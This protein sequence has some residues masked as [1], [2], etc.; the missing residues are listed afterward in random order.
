MNMNSEITEDMPT[1][2]ENEQSREQ[3]ECPQEQSML[4]CISNR[5]NSQEEGKKIIRVKCYQLSRVV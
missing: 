4:S 1:P 3:L 5:K 2:P